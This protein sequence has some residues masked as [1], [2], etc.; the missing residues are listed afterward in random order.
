MDAITTEIGAGR[1]GKRISPVTPANDVSDPDPQPLFNAVAQKLAG[2]GLAYVHVIDGATGGARDVQQGGAPF[3]YAAMRSAS[4]EEGGKGAWMVTNGYDG[5]L[6]AR[7]V[8]EGRAD[9]GAFGQWFIAQPD[10]G[11]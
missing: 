9:R 1:T 11:H 8:E 6:G 7:A 10:P 2:Y 5:G 4:V 3:D